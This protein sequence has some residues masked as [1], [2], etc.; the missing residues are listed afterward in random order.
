MIAPRGESR[1][2][3]PYLSTQLFLSE[4]ILIIDPEGVIVLVGAG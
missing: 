1:E 3:T 4:G 2:W